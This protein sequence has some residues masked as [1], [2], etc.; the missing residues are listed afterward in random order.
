TAAA[1][2]AGDAL[3]N[4][5]Q[6]LNEHAGVDGHVVHTLG[7]LLFDY[8]EH[9]FRIQVFDTLYAGNG[10]IDRNRSDRDRRVTEDGFAD[11][12]DVAARGEIHNRVGAVVNGGMELL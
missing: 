3:G 2:D 6:V 12:M 10:F 4:Q 11:F 5:R 9:D 7:R 1:D 8:F